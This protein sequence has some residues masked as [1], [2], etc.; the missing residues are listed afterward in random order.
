MVGWQPLA[1]LPAFPVSTM[2][3]LTD[4]TVFCQADTGSGNGGIDWWRLTPDQFGDYVHGSWTPLPAMHYT[5]EYF[6]S[7][8]LGDG[9]VFVAGGEYSNNGGDTSTAEIYDPALNTWTPIMAP[10]GWVSIGDAPC[11]V[12]PDGRV[13]L[14]SIK[15][16]ETALYDPLADVWTAGPDKLNNSNE[17]ETWTLLPDGSVLTVECTGSFQGERYVPSLAR[18]VSAGTPP[19]ALVQASSNEIGPAIL[20]PD[21]RVWVIGATGHT[22]LYTPPAT[23]DGVGAWAAGPDFPVDGNGHLLEAKDAPACLLPN[24]QV[25]CVAGPAGEGGNF[26]GPTSFF[27]F[28]GISLNPIAASPNSARPPFQGRILLLPTGQVLF[29]NQTSDLQVYTPDGAPHEAWRP[30]I[31]A[32]SSHLSRGNTH[33]LLGRQLNGLS[34][35]VSYGDDAT[36]ATNYPLIR[37]EHLANGKVWYCPTF[38]HTLGV[39]T[40]A[41]IQATSFQVPFTVEYGP[42]LLYLVANGISSECMRI[43]VTPFVRQFPPFDEQMVNFLIGSLADGPL[44]AL[45]PHGPVP[46]DPWGPHWKEVQAVYGNIVQSLEHLQALGRQVL[47]E[48]QTATRGE[49]QG[50]ALR[51]NLKTGRA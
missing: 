15:G 13:L 16:P 11:C 7:A 44:W 26:P 45:T 19:V 23:P 6:A 41:A 24:G 35:A 29:A 43:T 21:G 51:S 34:Q 48:R 25:L 20:L 5:R 1:T 17:E 38:G 8:V 46:V 32:L 36:M 3:L 30:H 18:W 31:T 28:D 14:G 40:G 33:T 49:E 39:A 9:R 4:G 50:V 27:L 37:I 10:P 2:L 47:A 22:A 12:L 42:A